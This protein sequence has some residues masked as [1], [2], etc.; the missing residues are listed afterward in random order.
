MTLV[1][2]IYSKFLFLNTS[3]DFNKIY[4]CFYKLILYL[5][6]YISYIY[7]IYNPI[8]KHLTGNQQNKIASPIKTT[9]NNALWDNKDK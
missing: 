7:I 3:F 4:F 9:M 5:S 8:L 2:I 6:N 1:F